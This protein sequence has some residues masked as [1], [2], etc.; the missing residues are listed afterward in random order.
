M[1]ASVLR[2]MEE[3]DVSVKADDCMKTS[4]VLP[5]GEEVT[6]THEYESSFVAFAV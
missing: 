2:D 5:S 1:K 6:E 3:K 4:I